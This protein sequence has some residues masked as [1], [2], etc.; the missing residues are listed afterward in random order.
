MVLS[1]DIWSESSNFFNLE[2][3]RDI[4]LYISS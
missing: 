2:F 3:Y 4:I 1:Y